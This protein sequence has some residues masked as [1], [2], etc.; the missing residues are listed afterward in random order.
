MVCALLVSTFPPSPVPGKTVKWEASRK[1]EQENARV[2]DFSPSATFP[3]LALP[4]AASDCLTACPGVAPQPGLPWSSPRIPP[5]SPR[6]SNGEPRNECV[7]NDDHR[8][9]IE[10]PPRATTAI[11]SPLREIPETYTPARRAPQ[12]MGPEPAASG[13]EGMR[14]DHGPGI[15]DL[16]P[17]ARPALPLPPLPSTEKESDSPRTNSL[18]D[19]PQR[20]SLDARRGA[21]G[22]RR[23][24]RATTSPCPRRPRLSSSRPRRRCRR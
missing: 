19:R 18:A 10:P 12:A 24:A 13:G 14:G 5:I 7:G 16:L 9:G 4:L 8:P 22:R 11:A 15:S 2:G 6:H 23:R 21:R 17:C 3:V 20:I 1:P